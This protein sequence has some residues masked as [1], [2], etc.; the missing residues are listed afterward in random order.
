MY[1]PPSQY[2]PSQYRLPPNTAAH[3]KSQIGFFKVILPPITAVSEYRRF[4]ASPKNGGI[5][6]DDCSSYFNSIL[7]AIFNAILNAETSVC[8]MTSL[9]WNRKEDGL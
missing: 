5:G 4:I 1:S 2:R 6:R 3:F 9:R 7:N 8:S